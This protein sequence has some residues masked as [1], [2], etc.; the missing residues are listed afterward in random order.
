MSTTET[1]HDR[2]E[3]A[4][5]EVTPVQVALGVATMAALAFVLMFMQDPMV[6]D[7]VHSFRHGVGITCH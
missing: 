4:R 7:A 1:V 5:T 6:H 2:F 3:Q